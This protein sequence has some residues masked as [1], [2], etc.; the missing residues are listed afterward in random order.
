[1]T[2]LSCFLV[3]PGQSAD[4][5]VFESVAGAIESE[6]VGVFNDSVDH[7]GGHDGVPE[8][9]AP[10]GGKVSSLVRISETC[11]YRLSTS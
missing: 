3:A 5:A 9:V 6:D 1:M 8:D 4:A 2:I 7:R 10:S 11:S